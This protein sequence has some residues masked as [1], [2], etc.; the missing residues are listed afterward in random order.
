[1]CEVILVKIQTQNKIKQKT[2][3]Q[4]SYPG[5]VKAASRQMG[6][7]YNGL[8]PGENTRPPS[9]KSSERCF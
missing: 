3:W 8:K 9:L 6:N 1:M 7:M 2:T 5:K 4:R